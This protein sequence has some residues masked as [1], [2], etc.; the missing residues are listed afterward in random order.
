MSWDIAAAGTMDL[1][2]ITTPHGRRTELLGGSVVYFTLSARNFARVH[3]HGVVGD[4]AADRFMDVLRHSNV[5]TAG[6]AVNGSPTRTWKARHDFDRWIAIVD[7]EDGGFEAEWDD[8]WNRKLTAVARQAPVLFLGSMS[9]EYQIEILDQSSARLVGSDSMKNFIVNSHD[10]VMDVV[11]RSNVLFVNHDELA[12]MCHAE[13][14]AWRESANGLLASVPDLRAVVVKAGPQGAA[15]VTRGGITER[16]AA[17]VDTVIDPTG[18]GDSLA[19]G[20]LGY[21]AQQE[22]SDDESFVAALDAGLACAARAIGSFGTAG[23]VP[24]AAI[25]R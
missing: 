23:V 9:P 22:R 5:E 19:A 12:A 3:M 8:D 10:R 13:L 7:G 25:S 16:A 11:A 21:C 17:P 2:D 20:F 4:D 24:A 1:D 18:A 14:D 15:L 6:I